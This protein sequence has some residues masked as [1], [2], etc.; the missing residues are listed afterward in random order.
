MTFLNSE[1]TRKAYLGKHA[2]N[3]ILTSSEQVLEIYELRGMVFPVRVSSTLEIIDRLPGISLSEIGRELSIPHQLVAQ[4]T[5]ILLKMSLIEKRPDP[6]DKR[7]SGFF[8]TKEGQKQSKLLKT[9]MADI[10]QVYEG[11]YAEIGCDLPS[12]LLA[13]I[14]ALKARPIIQRLEENTQDVKGENN[15]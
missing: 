5:S 11:L 7:R 1:T 15:D 9:C 10:A 14:E 6:K 2:Q 12:V 8:L 3:L 4:R 13:A